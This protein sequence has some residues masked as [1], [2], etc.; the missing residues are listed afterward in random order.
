MSEGFKGFIQKDGLNQSGDDLNL[1]I[2]NDEI[3]S[4]SL[5]LIKFVLRK[6]S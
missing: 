3:I 5:I 6:F 2:K 4:P 1:K